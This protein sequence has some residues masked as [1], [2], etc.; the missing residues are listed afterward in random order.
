MELVKIGEIDITYWLTTRKLKMLYIRLWI[1]RT[2]LTGSFLT[3][4]QHK[5]ICMLVTL[6]CDHI[7]PAKSKQKQN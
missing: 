1:N 5:Q 4:Y 3:H 2:Y 7:F 6:W